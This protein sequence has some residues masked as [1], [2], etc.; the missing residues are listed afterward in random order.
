MQLW[1]QV[2]LLASCFH[3]I[4]RST[5]PLESISQTY[6]HYKSCLFPEEKP[7][8][9]FISTSQLAQVYLL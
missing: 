4:L 5:N 8:A 1:Q 9:I 3:Q 7:Q 6:E 2:S